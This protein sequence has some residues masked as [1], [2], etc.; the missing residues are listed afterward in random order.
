MDSSAGLLYNAR[1]TIERLLDD[2][3]HGARA[4]LECTG[5]E[6]WLVPVEAVAFDERTILKCRY[7]C[8]AWGRRW[9]C[10]DR[11]W[12]PRELIPLL[13]RYRRVVVL[14]GVDGRELFPAA[15]ALERA[16]FARGFYWALAV[17][18]TPCYT[19]SECGYPA[20]GCRHVLDLRPESAMAG[21][22][23]FKT[24]EGLGVERMGS[25]GYLRVSFVFL[26]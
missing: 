10:N 9:T 4:H 16:A 5:V 6:A 14:T 12:G 2:L 24:L 3:L 22:D 13:R 1:V 7:S 17:A 21:I 23:T 15:L 26:D 20:A 18:V 19:C 11:A 8:P 25:E